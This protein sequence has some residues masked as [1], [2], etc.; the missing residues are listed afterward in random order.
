MP[1]GSEMT[2][3]GWTL[4]QQSRDPLDGRE[5]VPCSGPTL[6]HGAIHAPLP[7]RASRHERLIKGRRPA[8]TRTT[9]KS[10]TSD[11]SQ[12]HQFQHRTSQIE[13]AGISGVFF[14]PRKA[15]CFALGSTVADQTPGARSTGTTPLADR[16]EARRDPAPLPADSVPSAGSSLQ[17]S[18]LGRYRRRRLPP[19]IVTEVSATLVLSTILRRLAGSQGRPCCCS[20]GRIAVQFQHRQVFAHRPGCCNASENPPDLAGRRA[21]KHE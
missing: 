17:D 11:S 16:P 14:R 6:R 13:P 20:S 21:E 18:R 2:Q 8:A 12:T 3:K 1:H 19:S 4:Q 9:G 5:V 10:L 15:A 7:N